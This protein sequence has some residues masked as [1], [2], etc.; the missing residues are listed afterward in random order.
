[1]KSDKNLCQAGYNLL[2]QNDNK[3][4]EQEEHIDIM[5]AVVMIHSPVYGMLVQC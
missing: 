3:N 4:E 1:V 2:C 5:M